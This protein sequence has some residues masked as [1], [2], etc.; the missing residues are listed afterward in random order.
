[1]YVGV[2]ALRTHT[3]T[4][5]VWYLDVSPGVGSDTWRARRI[6]MDSISAYMYSYMCVKYTCGYMCWEAG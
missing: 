3:H 1:M 6:Q 4:L 2:Y 5:H